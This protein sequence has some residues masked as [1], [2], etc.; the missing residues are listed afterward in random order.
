[1]EPLHGPKSA[2][3]VR[4][5]QNQCPIR[6]LRPCHGLGS[7]RRVR[8][9][10]SQSPARCV[11]SVCGVKSAGRVHNSTLNFYSKQIR[12]LSVVRGVAAC[13]ARLFVRP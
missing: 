2:S 7:V 8:P 13:K 11:E 5:F 6:R 12:S 4:P 1:M 9:L 10:R 3:G